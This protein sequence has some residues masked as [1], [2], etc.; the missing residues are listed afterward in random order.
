MNFRLMQ[1]YDGAKK[2]EYINLHPSYRDNLSSRLKDLQSTSLKIRSEL[3]KELRTDTESSN[4]KDAAESIED[5][6][7]IIQ[8]IYNLIEEF[9]KVLVKQKL[10]L[11]KIISEAELEKI[12]P[13]FNGTTLPLFETFITE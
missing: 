2:T 6:R 1:L 3:S 12:L 4:S 5:N 9:D 11:N 13:S 10:N 8:H 7:N